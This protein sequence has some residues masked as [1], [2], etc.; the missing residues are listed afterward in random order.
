MNASSRVGS[1]GRTA[2][3]LT[4]FSTRTRVTSSATSAP[5]AASTAIPSGVSD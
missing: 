2:R 3:I 4:R 5:A 1:V